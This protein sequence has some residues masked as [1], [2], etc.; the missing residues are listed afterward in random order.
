MASEAEAAVAAGAGRGA[1]LIPAAVTI[2][3]LASD[4]TPATGVSAG[5]KG[6]TWLVVTSE[7]ST[8]LLSGL[9][10]MYSPNVMPASATTRPSA[11]AEAA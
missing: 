7:P 11:P 4:A 6:L 3:T 8:G 2:P 9:E 1:A 5:F 10:F